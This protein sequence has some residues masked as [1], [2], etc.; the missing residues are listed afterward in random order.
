MLAFFVTV[1]IL[2]DTVKNIPCRTAFQLGQCHKQVS[3]LIH[4]QLQAHDY[5][6]TTV[7]KPNEFKIHSTLTGSNIIPSSGSTLS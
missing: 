1:A 5:N 7:Y 4:L 2:R 6:E 3:Q